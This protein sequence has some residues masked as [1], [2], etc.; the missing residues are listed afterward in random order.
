[1]PG[2]L[3]GV[4]HRANRTPMARH[5]RTDPVTPPLATPPLPPATTPPSVTAPAPRW[6]PERW[7][8]QVAR[9]ARTEV[10]GGLVISVA[11]VAAL[12]WANLAPH[13]SYRGVWSAAWHTGLLPRGE[14]STARQWVDNGLMTIFFFA[15][16]LE[17]GRERTVGALRGLRNALL[18]VT[19]ALGGMVGAAFVYLFTTAA[20]GGGAAALKG[21]GVPMATDVAFTLGAMAL[22]GRKVPPALRVFVLALAVAD[23]VG[24]VVV[25]AFVASTHVRLWCVAGAV[26]CFVVAAAVLRRRV[27]GAWWPYVALAAVAWYLL[28]W[29][30]VEPSL[31]GAFVGMLTPCRRQPAGGIAGSPAVRLETI[32]A[33]ISAL[34]VLPLFALANTG[35]VISPHQLTTGESGTV[36]TGILV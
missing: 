6:R 18:P 4:Q 34:V 23:D 7:A 28:A 2:S 29:G 30:G 21:W 24:S 25:L 10:V 20:S 8:G 32:V 16:G 22:L 1:M 9:L 11:V 15:V 36:F 27:R 12:A 33:P 26:A 19:A 31:A 5:R 35:I 3:V 14:L 17:V 13:A